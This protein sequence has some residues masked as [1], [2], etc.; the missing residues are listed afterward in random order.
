MARIFW[1][2]LIALSV[3]EKI[4]K[5]WHSGTAL[6][7]N[8]LVVTMTMLFLTMGMNMLRDYA[9]YY[10]EKLGASPLIVGLLGSYFALLNFFIQTPG[11]YIADK[12]GRKTICWI[13]TYVLALANVFFAIA[14]HW[15]FLLIAIAADAIARLYVP[16]LNALVA[17]SIP[18]EDRPTAYASMM[19]VTSLPGLVMPYVGAY[20][21]S[22][23]DITGFRIGYL[24]AFALY[25][26]AATIRF[27]KLKETLPKR[28]EDTEKTSLL[29][30]IKSGL[31][32]SFVGVAY[33]LKWMKG[34]IRVLFIGN[35]ISD[36]AGHLTG[37]FFFFYSFY[38]IRLSLGQ[39]GIVSITFT[40]VTLITR[41]PL[42]KIC[43]KVGRGRFVILSSICFTSS[44]VV[45]VFAKSFPDVLISNVISAIGVSFMV[46]A[47]S[48]LQADLTPKEKRGRVLAAFYTI[49]LICAIPASTIGGYL[50]ENV[51]PS[52]PFFMSIAV[53][54]IVLGLYIF[55][56]KE[57]KVR[58]V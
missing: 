11:G 20:L 52:Y 39:L 7:G 46:P 29:T 1:F 23:M 56:L 12:Y 22:T 21:I 8:A 6:H 32:E 42:A 18:P 37:A 48:S 31:K 36:F 49:P 34:S 55:K 19:L 43:D 17:D 45:F 47:F 5:A 35:C 38:V 33:I 25:I 9:P 3:V 30:K 16:A 28:D 27:F 54:M 58:E 4:K 2:Q 24:I 44:T 50:Y 26:V 57:P 14:F 41:I 51:D 40:A 13:M 10:Y 15:S 53:N